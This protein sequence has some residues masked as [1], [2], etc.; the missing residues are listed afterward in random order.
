MAGPCLSISSDLILKVGTSVLSSSTVDT[1][2]GRGLV[3]KK[4]RLADLAMI[5]LL[6]PPSCQLH[7]VP[8]PSR[9]NNETQGA[10]VGDDDIPG[11]GSQGAFQIDSE[12][13]TALT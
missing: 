6:L 7:A 8:D 1:R 9:F 4:V 13:D 12:S 11:I 5:L 3:V 10:G 2:D